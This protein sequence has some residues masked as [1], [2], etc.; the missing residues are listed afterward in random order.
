MGWETDQLHE[1]REW[2]SM[3]IRKGFL[4]EVMSNNKVLKKGEEGLTLSAQ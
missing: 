3:E 4:L 2:V 1:K